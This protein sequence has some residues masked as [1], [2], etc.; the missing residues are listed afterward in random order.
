MYI[1]YDGERKK[2]YVMFLY[3]HSYVRKKGAN[4]GKKDALPQG[5]SEFRPEGKSDILK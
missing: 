3:I 4:R 2:V 1:L 5:K